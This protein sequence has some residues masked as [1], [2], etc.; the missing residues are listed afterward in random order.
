MQAALNTRCSTPASTSGR[1]AAPRPPARRGPAPARAWGGPPPPRPGGGGPVG[2]DPELERIRAQGGYAAPPPPRTSAPP[3]PPGGGAGG[4]APGGG[5]GGGE[6]GLS[7]YAKALVAAAFVTGLGAGV[8]F[9]AEINVSPNQ[10][11]STEIIDRRTPNSEVGA[12]LQQGGP[13]RLLGVRLLC[14]NAWFETRAGGCAA[15]G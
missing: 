15:P 4:P 6:G 12:G 7:G 14:S 2:T 13:R 11:A 3:P 9:D 8:Y 10:V 1:A 5:G